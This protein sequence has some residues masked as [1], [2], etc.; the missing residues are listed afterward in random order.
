MKPG[1][2][3]ALAVAGAASAA[4]AAYAFLVEPRWLELKRVRIHVRG[5][6]RSLE[7]LRIGL[8]T[9]L[10]AG[11]G[12]SLDRVRRACE[13]LMAEAPALVAVTGD[14]AAP[15]LKSFQPV[16]GALSALE[17]P[18]GVYTVPGNH[19]HKK[20]IELWRRELR[21]HSAMVDLTNRSVTLRVGE[22]RLCLAGVDDFALGDPTLDFLPDPAERDLT[23]LLAHNPDQAEHSRR[24]LDSI[25]L[26]LSGHT[27]GGQI[28]FP[29]VGSL[30]SSVDHAELY[31]EG[32]RR[33]PWTQVYTS[34]GLG[35]VRI[36]ARL[37]TRPEV[38]ILELTGDPRPPRH[39]RGGV[40]AAPV[41]SSGRSP[42][43]VG[44]EGRFLGG[45][46]NKKAEKHPLSG[47]E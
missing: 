3:G 10:H 45:F 41:E 1:W 18:L 40:P 15:K 44:K 25:D 12:R 46:R 24:A 39:G 13:R 7:G 16:L 34:R 31:E 21:D 38:S 32:L 14:L 26:V 33:R 20:G 11:P 4:L 35:T 37:L 29:G 36:P 43:D 2:R 30:V 23:V 22:A 8:I 9:D 27:H 6:H 42:Q 5:L 47:A 28:R 17:A 19:D